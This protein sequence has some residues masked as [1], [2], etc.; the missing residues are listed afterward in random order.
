MTYK[1]VAVV[2]LSGG[3][4]ST[5]LLYYVIKKMHYDTVFALGFDYGQQH[6]KELKSARRICEELGITFFLVEIKSLFEAQETLLTENIPIGLEEQEKTVVTMRNA[7]FLIVA[8]KKIIDMG[9]ANY[10]DKNRRIDI[11]FAPNLD[12]FRC[13]IDCRPEFVEAISKVVSISSDGLI[14]GVYAPFI[15]M[16]KA[17]IIKL[18]KELGVP[19]YLTWSCYKGGDKPCGVCPACIERKE[20]FENAGKN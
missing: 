9:L 15:G 6:K 12:D 16:T 10:E 17:E 19:Y 1:P 7:I 5:T 14:R 4:D 3:V 13:Y 11:F 20:A 2:L 8:A 18:G